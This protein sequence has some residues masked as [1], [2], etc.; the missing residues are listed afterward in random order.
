MQVTVFAVGVGS[1]IGKTELTAIASA[2]ECTHVYY[3]A[4]FN[5]ITA[6]T[7][8]IMNGACK[9][10]IEIIDNGSLSPHWELLFHP[11]NK[12]DNMS[13]VYLTDLSK[14]FDIIDRDIL[15][16]KLCQLGFPGS[17]LR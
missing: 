6:F 8:Q 5:D 14:A 12:S 2:P 15:V 3:L 10:D 11:L 16:T 9:G 17:V 1:S 13:L 7:N 4:N